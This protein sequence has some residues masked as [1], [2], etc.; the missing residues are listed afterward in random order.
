MKRTKVKIVF[1][2]VDGDPQ[3]QLF[4]AADWRVNINEGVFYVVDESGSTIGGIPLDKM[5][6]FESF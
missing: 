3:E 4:T 1:P 6:Y 2:G 5:L